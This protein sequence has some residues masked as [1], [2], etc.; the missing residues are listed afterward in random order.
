[1]HLKK[2]QFFI[3]LYP[4]MGMGKIWGSLWHWPHQPLA[5]MGILLKI[6]ASKH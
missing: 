3:P 5:R 4:D 2:K 1:M 6:Q